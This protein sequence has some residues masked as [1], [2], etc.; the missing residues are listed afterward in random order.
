VFCPQCQAEYRRGFTHC[1]DCDVDL[2]HE[3]SPEHVATNVR[4]DET[5]ITRS[6]DDGAR[7]VWRGIVQDYCLSLCYTLRE[8]GITYRVNET[9]GPPGRRLSIGRR[10]ELIVPAEDYERSKTALSVE[11]DAPDSFTDEDWRKLEN[12]EPPDPEVD[13]LPE[14]PEAYE[15]DESSASDI[16]SDHRLRRDA[17]FRPWYP[18]DATTEIWSQPDSER[19]ADAIEMA[20]KEH[21]IHCSV[22]KE[23]GGTKVF[24]QPQ[25]ES[26]ARSVVRDIAEALS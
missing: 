18:E 22:E 13:T 10:Y 3:L 25:D 19:Q 8:H 20:L 9:L 24:V 1:S 17:Y 26:L 4:D 11:V 15:S 16:A 14:T 5:P 6:P 21:F 2:V 12:P 7:V 23:A